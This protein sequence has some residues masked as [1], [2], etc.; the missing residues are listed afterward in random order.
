MPF[1]NEKEGPNSD[2]WRTVD[3]DRDAILQ[4]HGSTHGTVLPGY[5]QGEK[6]TLVWKGQAISFQADLIRSKGDNPGKHD[7]R[8]VVV[9]LLVPGP[10]KTRIHEIRELIG[11]GLREW[12]YLYDNSYP[13]KVETDFAIDST[14]KKLN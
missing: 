7:Y 2:N 4:T 9:K 5:G 12:G 13:N 8:W 3:Y 14:Q 10:C 11:D 1:V 6:F